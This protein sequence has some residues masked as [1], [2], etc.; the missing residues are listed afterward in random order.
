MEKRMR[1]V[2]AVIGCASVAL[3]LLLGIEVMGDTN[4]AVWSG[5]NSLPLGFFRYISDSF[6][7]EWLWSAAVLGGI[8]A[9]IFFVRGVPPAKAG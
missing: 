9:A 7:H 4:V 8:I 3:L 6:S 1:S 2:V 5:L